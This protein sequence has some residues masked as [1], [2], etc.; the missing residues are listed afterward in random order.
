MSEV[1]NRTE[2]WC[3]LQVLW[4]DEVEIELWRKKQQ[5][6][7]KRTI[8][9]KVW[10]LISHAASSIRIIAQ[11]E[12]KMVSL[13]YKFEILEATHYLQRTNKRKKNW[14]WKENGF[15]NRIMILNILHHGL[16]HLKRWKLKV[17]E[18]NSQSFVLNII[19][20][21]WVDLI[22]AVQAPPWEY[23]SRSRSF[24]QGRMRE[25]PKYKNWKTFSWLQESFASSNI[26][27]RGCYKVLTM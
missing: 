2:A 16:Q 19:I 6:L 8:C 23:C 25:N 22:R 18:M 5:H 4:T 9:Q 11:V 21:T 1:C 26:Y 7:M 17:L 3:F 15:C 24:V 13:K 20:N 10:A 12:S 14:S 27:Q